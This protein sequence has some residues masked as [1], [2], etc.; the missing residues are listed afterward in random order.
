MLEPLSGWRKTYKALEPR[1]NQPE[2][3]RELANWVNARVSGRLQ[4]GPP[5][6]GNSSF[7][8]ARSVFEKGLKPAKPIRD[9]RQG[10]L[11]M[12]NAWRQAVS[13]SKM[14][15]DA[16]AAVGVVT[17]FTLFSS[18]SSTRIDVVSVSVG[19]AYL[20][21]VLLST[22][23]EGDESRLPEYFRKAFSFLTFTIQG[24]NS[25]PPPAGPLPLI[26]PFARV[27]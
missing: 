2:G 14:R 5:L 17:P 9:V 6:V 23:N 22:A 18:V 27:R 4:I 20:Y 12:A 1:I 21:K 11:L 3:I 13:Q 26:L 19:Y 25:V 7:T 15:V 10:R 16:G 24:R 8:F